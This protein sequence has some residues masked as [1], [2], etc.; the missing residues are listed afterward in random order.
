MVASV[1][2]EEGTIG[3]L[4]RNDI[5][6]MTYVLMKKDTSSPQKERILQAFTV[7]SEKLKKDPSL[8]EKFIAQ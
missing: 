7:V 5:Q 6:L 1:G 3:E 4:L 2:K 8:Y